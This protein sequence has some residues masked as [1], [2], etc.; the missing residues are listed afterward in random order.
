MD[1]AAIQAAASQWQLQQVFPLPPAVPPLPP[2]ALQGISAAAATPQNTPVP[3]TTVAAVGAGDRP[4]GGD[5]EEL[6]PLPIDGASTMA[7]LVDYIRQIQSLL[8][9]HQ[10]ALRDNYK[11][12]KFQ[13]LPVIG[14]KLELS[15]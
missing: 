3:P 2:S 7:N 4:G 5:L 11:E 8:I 12:I 9:T 10:R 14:D 15:D 13:E 6:V 1:L